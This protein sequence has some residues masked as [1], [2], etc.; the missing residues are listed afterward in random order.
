MAFHGDLSSFPLPELLQWLDSSRKTGALALVWD[1]GERKV[2]L[3]SGQV[4]ATASRGLSE[5]VARMLALARLAPAERVLAGFAALHRGV[6]LEAAFAAQG[7]SSGPSMELAREELVAGMA[8][9]TMSGA[10]SFHW[11]EDADRSGEE[12]AVVSVGLR[13]LLFESLRWVDEAPDVERALGHEGVLVRARTPPAAHLPVVKQVILRLCE[14]GLSLSRLRLA[15][16]LSRTHAFRRTFD[17]LRQ[18]LVEVEGAGQPQVD[19]VSDMLEKGAVLLRE[20]Q[21]DAAALVS[22]T[23]L[24]SD[25]V[26]R[27]VREY[28]RLVEREHI[29]ALYASLPPLHRLVR[30]EAPQALALLRPEER[31]LLSLINGSWD[32]STLVLA[33]QERELDTLKAL[34]KLVRMGLVEPRGE[35]G[36][37]G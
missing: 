1:G 23:L 35:P 2:F 29:A 34:T 25:P 26:D 32:V 28:A 13:E 14:K 30:L 22:S 27:R 8:D 10:G 33:S 24:S 16:G 21:F 5:R 6:E 20:Q 4:V 12:W 3:L 7:L 31:H 19:P 18:R 11:T 15:L 37:H 17:M 9:L 36:P